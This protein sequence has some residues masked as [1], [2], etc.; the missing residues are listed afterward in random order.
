MITVTSAE[1][2]L[3]D[4][5][6]NVI[7][8]QINTNV[9]PLFS[10]IQRSTKNIHGKDVRILAPI[11]INGGICAGTEAGDLPESSERPFLEFVSSLKNLYGRFQISDKALKCTSSDVNSFVNLV[12]EGM[13]SL[14]RASIFNLSR[15]IYGDGT[16]LLGQ[17]QMTSS[18]LYVDKIENFIEGMLIDAYSNDNLLK[19]KLRIKYVNRPLKA[20][21]VDQDFRPSGT[22]KYYQSGSKNNEITGLGALG[23]PS[24]IYGNSIRDYPIL[25]PK[26]YDSTY[27][28]TEYVFDDQFIGEVIDTLSLRGTNVNFI[29][30]SF[31]LKRL[32]LEY[33]KLYNKNVD[34]RQI[35]NG[36]TVP[37]FQGI[38]LVP[39]AMIDKGEAY[40][41]NTDDFTFYELGDW[42]WLEDESGRVL[43][44]EANKPV[45]GATLVKYTELICRKPSGIGYCSRIDTKV[46]QASEAV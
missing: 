24:E 26:Q 23:C 12:E 1:N 22:V 36:M 42:R 18:V 4:V 29:N 9:N 8:E 32:F 41:L 2:L 25:L 13:D 7:A 40:F 3:K 34:F 46:K 5:Y 38:P 14:L 31:D 11:G 20:I 30:L 27:D 43:K 15:M 17:G 35:E 37:V 28:L 19:T 45:F 44:Q 6:V 10:R 39:T 33:M 21:F 16:G